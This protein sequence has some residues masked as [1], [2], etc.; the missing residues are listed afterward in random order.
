MTNV[1]D[2]G[3]RNNSSGTECQMAVSEQHLMTDLFHTHP[4][5]AMQHLITDLSACMIKNQMAVKGHSLMLNAK[6][7]CRMTTSENEKPR[8]KFQ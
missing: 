5:K 1:A 3:S 4:V 7:A 2:A 8:P 6:T